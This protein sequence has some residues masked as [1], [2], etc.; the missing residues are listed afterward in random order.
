[1]LPSYSHSVGEDTS[2]DMDLRRSL[3]ESHHVLGLLASISALSPARR[4]EANEDI[5]GGPRPSQ[6]HHYSEQGLKACPKLVVT[7][8]P[9]STQVHIRYLH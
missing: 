9:L 3:V 5:P 6:H 7:V 8:A 2:V 4:K 1:M